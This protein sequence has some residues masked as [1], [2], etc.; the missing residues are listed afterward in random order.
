MLR[1]ALSILILCGGC[2]LSAFAHVE[3]REVE[4]TAGD[5]TMKGYLAWNNDMEEPRPAVLVVHEWWGHNDYARGRARNL[6]ALGYVALAVDMYGDGRTADHPDEAG[7]FAGKVMKDLDVARARF[8]AAMEF[9]KKQ[10][11]VDPEHLAAMGY[12]FGGGVALHMARMGLDLDGVASFHGSLAAKVPA[13]KGEVK[14]SVLVCHGAE[15]QF[16]TA[17]QI[18]E[19]KKEMKD[20]EVDLVFET[21]PGA[22]HSFT[23]PDADR[24]AKDLG[25]P[26]GYSPEADEAS[27]T[28]LKWFLARVFAQ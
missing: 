16:V 6:A 20:A 18:A 8:T 2:A 12:C 4:Y 19:F 25:L 7:A 15:D 13:K 21:Y 11:A 3:T 10:P 23:N 27:W 1:T 22:R 9:L 5:T 26:I 28:E 14:A 24:L 17:D